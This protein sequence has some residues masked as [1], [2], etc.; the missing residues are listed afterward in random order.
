MLKRIVSLIAASAL[1]VNMPVT[2]SAEDIPGDI[3]YDDFSGSSLDADGG[4][5]CDEAECDADSTA[6]APGDRLSDYIHP[7]EQI[8]DTF[9]F[10]YSTGGMRE[11][12]RI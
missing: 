6:D 4:G 9:S 7:R 11:Y 10:G 1:A 2:S 8:S 3:F 5:E 12:A